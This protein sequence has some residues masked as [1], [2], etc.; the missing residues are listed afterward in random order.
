[1]IYDVAVI[2]AGVIG[3]MVAMELS[4]YNLKNVLIEKF[5]DVAMGTTKANSAIVHAGFDAKPGTL[6]A[7][8]NVEG[9][10]I[11]PEICKK[12][13]VP[14]KNIGS[15]VVAFSEEQMETVK[16][17]YDRG[18]KNGV[19]DMEII[20]KAKLRELE[21]H[22]NE[23]ACGAL[24]AKTAGIV[25]P[26]QLAIAS[27]ENAVLNGTEVKL[28]FE[29]DKIDFNASS[30]IFTIFAGKKKIQAKY[31]INCAGIYSG[32]MASL[33]GDDSIDIVFRKGEYMLLDKNMG[34]LSNTVIFQCPSEMG[35]GILVTNTVDGNL[36]I[37]PSSI[38]IGTVDEDVST[39]ADVLD[40]VLLSAKLSVPEV[41]TRNVITSFAG[42]RAHS[43]TDDFIIK[44]SKSNNFFINVAGI[45]SP[46]LSA[47]PAIGIYVRNMLLQIMGGAQK[48][49][50][51][52]ESRK[53]P[54]RFNELSNEERKVLIEQD[55]RYGRIICRCETITEG[56]ILDA[57]HSPIPAKDVD[58]VKRRTRAGMGRCQGGFCGS[59]VVE[60]LAKE[61]GEELDDITKFGGK[62]KLLVGKTK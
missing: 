1:M 17:L 35:K 43:P 14:F 50:D 7:K 12:L 29:V 62:S 18:I 47:A 19:P 23:I 37:G 39:N 56:E 61:N 46:G 10:R 31:I 59:K 45:E 42:L 33:I 38:D 32:K 5:N 3:S 16:E 22:I 28:N 15:V 48:K 25:C 34:H 58:A 13:H 27:A 55:K 60:L 2:G 57:I 44:P 21:P 9:T 49:E 26:Y 40:S 24:Y 52:E 41:N 8:L 30:K 51:F 11:M 20:D 6:K 54:V 36:L 4:H 53:A